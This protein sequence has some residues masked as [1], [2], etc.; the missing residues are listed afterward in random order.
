MSGCGRD[1]LKDVREWSGGPPGCPEEVGSLSRMPG[2]FESPSRLSRSGREAL[3]N[4]W[5]WSGVP[6]ACP[7]VVVRPSRMS[8]SVRDALPYVQ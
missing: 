2:V 7:R 5:E 6:P 1:T 4:V 3:S 8:G